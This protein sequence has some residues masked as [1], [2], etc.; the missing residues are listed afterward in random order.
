M[1]VERERMQ[2]SIWNGKN[3][4][5]FLM[6]SVYT[7]VHKCINSWICAKKKLC[8][9]MY[10]IMEKEMATNS[11]ILAWRIPWKEEPRRL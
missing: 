7:I 11:S 4:L 6:D 8:D 9:C 5:C 1:N 2:K 3:I 10:F